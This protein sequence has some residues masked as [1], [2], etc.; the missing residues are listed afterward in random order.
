MT[1]FPYNDSNVPRAEEGQA[2]YRFDQERFQDIGKDELKS[3]GNNVWDVHFKSS[4]C[5][6]LSSSATSNNMASDSYGDLDAPLNGKS[7]WYSNSPGCILKRPSSVQHLQ[8]SSYIE[9]QPTREQYNCSDD[10]GGQNSKV[11]MPI[12]S[13]GFPLSK[14]AG[15]ADFLGSH[16]SCN[17][18][19]ACPYALNN[20][21]NALHQQHD[22][23][24]RVYPLPDAESGN[25]HLLNRREPPN[26]DFQYPRF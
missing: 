4:T 26:G 12:A 22:D 20:G 23:Q 18:V 13:Y 16:Q 9:W 10:M 15:L 11:A 19:P 3:A 7:F 6:S 24:D 14:V 5:S 17:A 21:S 8:S 2:S 25:E 1:P